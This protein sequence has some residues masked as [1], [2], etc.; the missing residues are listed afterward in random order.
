MGWMGLHYTQLR[1]FDCRFYLDDYNYV[2][3]LEYYRLTLTS[4]NFTCEFFLVETKS[5]E[6]LIFKHN[7]EPDIMVCVKKKKTVCL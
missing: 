3:A 6:L 7:F 2:D 1:A 4:Q 5:C